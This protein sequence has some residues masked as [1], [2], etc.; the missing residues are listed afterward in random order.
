MGRGGNW[1]TVKK[2]KSWGVKWQSPPT[3]LPPHWNCSNPK[4]KSVPSDTFWR[5]KI[6]LNNSTC[7]VFTF[8]FSHIYL[9]TIFPQT[10]FQ[11]CVSLLCWKKQDIELW[12]VLFAAGLLWVCS[13]FSPSS[14]GL[15]TQ[16]SCDYSSLVTSWWHRIQ[17]ATP[18]ATFFLINRGHF[19]S[20][21]SHQQG[22]AHCISHDHQNIKGELWTSSS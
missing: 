6:S 10:H 5:Q 3:P 2:R 9:L 21:V 15:L 7:W 20:A 17:Y 19:F 13:C 4:L 16:L 18:R 22:W 12:F 8:I 1:G 11:N 14:H